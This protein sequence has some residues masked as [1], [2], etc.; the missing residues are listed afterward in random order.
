M[1]PC[2][3]VVNWKMKS[4][5]YGKFNPLNIIRTDQEIS[6]YANW[7]SSYNIINDVNVPNSTRIT[8]FLA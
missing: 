7:Q 3:Q 8:R 2:Y 5:F 1:A 4:L 6:F